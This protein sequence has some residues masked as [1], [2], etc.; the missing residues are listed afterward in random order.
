MD[1]RKTPPHSD[2]GQ[3]LALTYREAAASLGVCERTVWGLVR[4]GELPAI[5]IGRSVRIPVKTLQ[6]FVQ[7]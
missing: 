1:S 4:D 3:K 7:S 5:R 6:D 2:Q